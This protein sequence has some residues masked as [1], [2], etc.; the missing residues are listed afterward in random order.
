VNTAIASAAEETNQ[1][2]DAGP[3][4]YALVADN[5]SCASLVRH[6]SGV[7]I[8]GDVA[9][10]PMTPDQAKRTFGSQPYGS[11]RRLLSEEVAVAKVVIALATPAVRPWLQ[12]AA[13]LPASAA[14][15]LHHPEVRRALFDALAGKRRRQPAAR[16]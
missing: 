16:H 10:T 7:L 9:L 2:D 4:V 12:L 8:L 13:Q 6:R 14:P 1:Q 3:R 11:P 5:P 15:L